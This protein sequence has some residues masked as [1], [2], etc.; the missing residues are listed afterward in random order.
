[1]TITKLTPVWAAEGR[2]THAH[3]VTYVRPYVP[4]PRIIVGMLT[5][6]GSLVAD[7]KQPVERSKR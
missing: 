7:A 3:D 1:M 5:G 6:D 4:P 2:D